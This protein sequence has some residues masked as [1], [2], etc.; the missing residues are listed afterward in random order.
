ML[1][2][3]Y[4]EKSFILET[5]YLLLYFTVFPLGHSYI[6]ILSI[7]FCSETSLVGEEMKQRDKCIFERTQVYPE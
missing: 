6:F 1:I 5:N 2:A 7:Y 3:I 4:S